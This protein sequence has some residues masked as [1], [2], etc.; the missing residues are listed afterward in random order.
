MKQVFMKIK[1]WISAFPLGTFLSF[2]GITAIILIVSVCMVLAVGSDLNEAFSGFVRGIIGSPYNFGEVLVRAAPLILAGLG[3]MASFRTGFINIGAEGQIYMGAIGFTFAGLFL[4]ALPP[5]LMLPAGVLAG[6]FL[7]GIWSLIPGFLKARFGISEIINTIMFNYIAINLTGLLL[8]TVL[9]DPAS[10]FP[11]SPMVGARFPILFPATRLHAG[12][13]L[14][15]LAAFAVHL[16]LFR[17]SRGFQMRAV[18]LN[19]RACACTGISPYKNIVFS[20]FLSGGLA[21]MAGLGEVAGLHHRLLEGISPGFGYTAIIVSLLG[22]NHPA[23]VVISALGIAALQM[24]SRSMERTGVPTAIA[25]VI[26]GLTVLL[27]LSRK[28]VF[29]P[30]LKLD[31][32]EV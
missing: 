3:V 27:I 29:A 14:A 25:T 1:Q 15:L 5:W 30:L 21:G 26:M 18:G 20:S 32:K 24:G 10:H 31:K 16:L 13:V 12:F 9:G 6:F 19:A 17:T 11:M 4:P 7:G 23:G 22:R 8:Q 28:N 2:L